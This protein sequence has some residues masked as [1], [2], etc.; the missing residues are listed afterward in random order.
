MSIPTGKRSYFGRFEEPEKYRM[1]NQTGTRVRL[2]SD[3]LDRHYSSCW[4]MNV[5][6]FDGTMYLAPTDERANVGAHTRLVSYDHATDTM[7]VCV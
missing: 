2:V 1:I 3:V 6:P 7:K 4:D 5:S